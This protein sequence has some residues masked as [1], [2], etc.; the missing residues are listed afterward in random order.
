MIRCLKGQIT[1]DST[2][3]ALTKAKLDY[4][5]ISRY[6]QQAPLW[7]INRGPLNNSQS[8]SNGCLSAVPTALFYC[9][10]LV[11]VIAVAAFY[12]SA[13][14]VIIPETPASKARI[15]LE[16]PVYKGRYILLNALHKGYKEFL[17]LSERKDIPVKE[18]KEKALELAEK[19]GVKG[20][21]INFYQQQSCHDF[22]RVELRHGSVG[23][24]ESSRQRVFGWPADRFRGGRH[25]M[26]SW[27]FC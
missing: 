22:K 27:D 6:G 11:I 16:T 25:S 2:F 7:N 19:Y 1:N 20:G 8:N 4:I 9:N 12:A 10:M 14:A 21:I 17:T 18:M 3:Q 26:S 13:E 15:M 5:E 23:D 24:P